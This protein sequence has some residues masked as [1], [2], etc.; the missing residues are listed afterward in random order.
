MSITRS[1]ITRQGEFKISR[2]FC[3]VKAAVNAGF[4]YY[5]RIGGTSLYAR[6]SKNGNLR[7]AVL[8]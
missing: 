7:Y 8:G 5:G 6:R 2:V 1:R 3:T 4:T